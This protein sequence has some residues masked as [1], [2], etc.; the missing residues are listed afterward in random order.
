MRENDDGPVTIDKLQAPSLY[1]V[2]DNAI[3]SAVM[4]DP[5]EMIVTS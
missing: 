2:T 1:Q 4:R 5:L 3:V